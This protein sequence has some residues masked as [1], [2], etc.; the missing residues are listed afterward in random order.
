MA[1]KVKIDHF[2]EKEDGDNADIKYC[3][4]RLCNGSD[5]FTVGMTS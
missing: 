2:N 1:K 3:I 5:C 4:R